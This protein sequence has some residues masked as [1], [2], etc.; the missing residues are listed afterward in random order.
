MADLYYYG[1]RGLPLDQ[2]RALRYFEQAAALGDE[3]GLCGAA[4]MYL[5]GEGLPA[6]DAAKAIALYERAANTTGSI[7]AH[8]GLGY[9]YF[10]GK[11]APQNFTKA[12]ESFMAAAA[13]GLDSD[14]V[15]N[16]A[17]CWEHGLGTEVDLTRAIEMYTHAAQK[18]GHFPSIYVLAQMH[19]EV[20]II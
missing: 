17:H 6:A 12:F 13:S 2:P 4:N 11:S 10:F 1:A 20:R 9:I 18:L 15:F 14:S 3:G 19:A 16:A 8:N 5:K 7:R